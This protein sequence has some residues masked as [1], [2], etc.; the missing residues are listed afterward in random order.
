MVFFS[1]Q[2]HKHTQRQIQPDANMEFRNNA[3]VCL[4]NHLK[5]NSRQE[6]NYCLW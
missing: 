2:T 5:Q 4:L 6:E 3:G 1:S